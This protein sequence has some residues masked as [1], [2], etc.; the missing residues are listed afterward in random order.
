M[1]L[2]LHAAAPPATQEPGSH[3][4]DSGG[5]VLG[6]VPHQLRGFLAQFRNLHIVGAAYDRCTGCSET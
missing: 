6:L 4:E 5:S 2:S 3:H 1:F